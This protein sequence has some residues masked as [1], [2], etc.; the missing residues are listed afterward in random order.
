[1]DPRDLGPAHQLSDVHDKEG[2]GIYSLVCMSLER[3]VL[4]CFLRVAETPG[5][6][7]LYSL[8]TVSPLQSGLCKMHL[9]VIGQGS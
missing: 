2:P 7:G 8:A 5:S 3:R 1:M 6:L 9:K 4:F